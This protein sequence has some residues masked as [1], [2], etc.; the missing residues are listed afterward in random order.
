M[1]RVR[2]L[3]ALAVCAPIE[4]EPGT[5]RP[6]RAAIARAKGE[7]NFREQQAFDR[8][9]AQLVKE[10]PVPPETA[11]WFANEKLAEGRRR[12]WRT[13]VLHPAILA[14]AIALA[15]IA[16]IAWLKFDEQMHAFPG[17]STAKRLLSLATTTRVS[18][19]EQVQADAGTLGDFFLMKY[20]LS[21][22]DVPAEFAQ[23]RTIG[24]RVFDDEE[25][26]R[27]A[28]IGMAEKRMQ[29]FL[30]PARREAKTGQPEEFEGWRYLEQ[31]G[32]SGAVHARNGVCFMAVLRGPKQEF[33]SYL[34]SDSAR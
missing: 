25:A 9:V 1:R 26:G 19:F 22:Y 6:M 34:R 8:A 16:V 2:N 3:R 27:V 12:S 4:N 29:F 30:F 24:T 21:H 15:V 32:W 31:D 17:A 13:T 7:K 14:T 20:R 5:D 11:Q 18:Q 33:A 10:T 28:Q 23:L